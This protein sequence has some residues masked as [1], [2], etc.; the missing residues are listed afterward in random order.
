MNVQV[1][2]GNERATLLDNSSFRFAGLVS[3]DREL[4]FREAYEIERVDWGKGIQGCVYRVGSR[5]FE[6]LSC[7]KGETIRKLEIPDYELRLHADGTRFLFQY[8]DIPTFD[9]SDREWDSTFNM[10]VYRDGET[11]VVIRCSHG[12]KIPRI[13]IFIGLEKS[14]EKFTRALRELD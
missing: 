10:C 3:E 6:D 13:R 7:M 9:S 5:E 8:E 4:C 1:I 12:Y 2:M 11:V 14:V